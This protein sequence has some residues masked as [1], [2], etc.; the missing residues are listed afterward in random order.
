VGQG[1][2]LTEVEDARALIRRALAGDP[3][4][5]RVLV[6]R[7]SPVVAKR[8]AATLWQRTRR[9]SAAQ[10]IADMVQEVLLSLFQADGK[11]LRAW[12]PERG[13]SL[14]RFVA[15]LAQHQVISILRN[16]RSSPWHDE[17]TES[18]KLEKLGETTLTPESIATSRENL[19][20]LLDR[21]RA[22]LSPRGLEL[23]QRMIVDEEPVE[24]LTAST[25]LTAD[26]LY[27]WKSRLLRTVRDLAKDFESPAVSET[28]PSLRIVKGAPQ[29]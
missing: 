7:L 23:F 14:D 17:P 2:E 25:G 12:D 20:L 18:E 3:R 13:M 21:L 28:T 8:V 5:A 24:E 11:A 1:G 4:S 22:T 29:P 19:A 27:Q 10:E 26:A 6:D 15:M 16:G 9:R